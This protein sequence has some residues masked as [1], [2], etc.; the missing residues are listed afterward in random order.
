[1]FAVWG[2]RTE[3]SALFSARNLDWNKDTGI[4]KHKVVMVIVPNDGGIPSA[5]LGFACL[6]GTLAGMSAKGHSMYRTLDLHDIVVHTVLHKSY[7]EKHCR[8]V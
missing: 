2:G 4:N 6:F 1:M 3:E 7:S 5:T 8:S